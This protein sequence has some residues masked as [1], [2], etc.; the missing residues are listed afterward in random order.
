MLQAAV[1][2][3]AG[4]VVDN[5]ELDEELFGVAAETAVVHLAVIRQL[6]NARLGTADV[7]ARGEV[8][9]GGAKPWREKGTGRARQGSNRAPHWKGGGV[10]FGPTPRSYAKEMPKKARRL[11]LA[12]ALSAKA[13][14]EQLILLSELSLPAAKTREILALLRRLAVGSSAL[15]VLGG[16]DVTVQR[17]ARNLRGV[18]AVPVTSLNVVDVLRHE[19][20]VLPVKALEMIRQT[21]GQA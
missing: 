6:A 2:N 4:E 20:I 11:A 17:A 16:P 5:V 13:R 10:V 12:A 19:Y 18:K 3:V 14:D 9:G 8:S 1:Y 15:I 21:W 7:K